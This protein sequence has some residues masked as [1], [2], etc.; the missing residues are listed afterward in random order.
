MVK[1]G[2]IVIVITAVTADINMK[3]AFKI[4]QAFVYC[5]VVEKWLSIISLAHFPSGLFFT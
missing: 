4:N 1:G 5:T 3:N 2:R